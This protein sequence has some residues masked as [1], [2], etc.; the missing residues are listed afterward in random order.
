[1]NGETWPYRV[2]ERPYKHFQQKQP[3]GGRF[4]ARDEQYGQSE[5]NENN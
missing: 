3:E 2:H 4:D 1:M 5:T